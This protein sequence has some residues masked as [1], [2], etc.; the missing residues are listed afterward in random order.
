MKLAPIDPILGTSLAFKSDPN[1]NKMN[2]GVG[3]YRDEQ[4]KPYIFKTVKEAERRISN[5]SKINKEYLPIDGLKGLIVASQKVAFGFYE[6]MYNDLIQNQKLVTAQTISGTG[7][8]FIALTFL[9]IHSPAPVY[10]SSPTWGN[11]K[12]I[13]NHVG[14]P[15]AEYPY[16][17]AKTKGLNFEGMMKTLSQAKPGSIILLHACAHNPTGVD[18]S[19]E[20]WHILGD[21][22]KARKLLPY[23]DSAYQGFASGDFKKDSVALEIFHSKGLNYMLSQ[24][25]AKNFG[26]YGERVGAL[27][28]ICQN[29]T[30][31]A[32]VLSQLKLVIR[33]SY[34][35]PPIHGALFCLLYT[36]PSPRD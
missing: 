7:S 3:A 31:S 26:L 27:H 25:F 12:A 5:D 32:K 21:L 28:I 14:L 10:I 1:P 19:V 24:S 4:G 34:S 13:I 36:S 11:H 23:F 29:K 2:L 8:L 9:K 17:D 22:I 20:Q 16:W 33:R 18:L 35:N 6:H 15:L 30:E